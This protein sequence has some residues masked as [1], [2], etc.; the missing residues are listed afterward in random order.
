MTVKLL[1]DWRN[2]EITTEKELADKIDDRVKG[3]L[4]DEVC[5]EEYLDDYIDCN[6]TKMELFGILASGNQSIIEETLDD[7]RSSVAESIR[8]WCECDVRGDYD[9]V[10]LEV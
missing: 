4:E 8:D 1:V 2:R 5:Y 10:K 7:I 6:Y 9:E 3:M